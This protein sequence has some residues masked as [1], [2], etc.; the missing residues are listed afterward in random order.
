MVLPARQAPGLLQQEGGAF[1]CDVELT[2]DYGKGKD[3][4]FGRLKSPAGVCRKWRRVEVTQVSGKKDDFV[5]ADKTD[6]NGEYE[7]IGL[8]QDK[9]VGEKFK[10]HVDRE[11]FDTRRGRVI[12]R[13]ATSRVLEVEKNN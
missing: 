2:I 12:C 1:D 13:A 11:T 8:K 10:A 7:E 4:F 3:H 6:R 5:G 9:A